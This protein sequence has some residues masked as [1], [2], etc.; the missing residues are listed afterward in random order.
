MRKLRQLIRNVLNVPQRKAEDENEDSSAEDSSS[1]EKEELSAEDRVLDK[2]KLE[3]SKVKSL[4]TFLRRHPQ[5]ETARNELLKALR[6]TN[7]L[8]LA[9]EI[10][11]CKSRAQGNGRFVLA[12]S[13]KYFFFSK[14]NLK[15]KFNHNTKNKS[16]AT[17]SSFPVYI[18]SAI[19]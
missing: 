18:Y 7:Q 2:V 11:F 3:K 16:L 8:D 9:S 13:Y 1:E 6:R 15:G 12:C 17:R 19:D 5:Q 10:E 4:I 14:I